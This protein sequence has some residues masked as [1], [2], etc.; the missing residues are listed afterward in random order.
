MEQYT[1]PPAS[2]PSVGGLPSS[3]SLSKEFHTLFVP[4][5]WSFTFPISI[6]EHILY[7]WISA[8]MSRGV[9]RVSVV[10]AN[11]SLHP[12]CPAPRTQPCV[13]GPREWGSKRLFIYL[14][15]HTRMPGGG[16]EGGESQVASTPPQAKIKSRIPNRL[17]HSGAPGVYILN[18]YIVNGYVSTYLKSLIF[19]PVLPKIFIVCPFKKKF[20]D[21]HSRS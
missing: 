6:V 16:A 12:S 15:E 5:P 2:P 7:T 14:R 17:S 10:S 19:R 18:G 20:T 9:R 3:P 13:L 4:I 8:P 21:P 11:T 1:C